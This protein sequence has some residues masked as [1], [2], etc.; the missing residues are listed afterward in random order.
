VRDGDDVLD[1]IGWIAG[2]GEHADLIRECLD[3][4]NL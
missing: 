3:L 1:R 2:T 4:L